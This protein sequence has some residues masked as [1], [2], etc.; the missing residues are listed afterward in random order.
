V[1]VCIIKFPL[2]NTL[3]GIPITTGAITSGRNSGLYAFTKLCHDIQ[4]NLPLE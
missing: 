3:V 4:A 2:V 1:L